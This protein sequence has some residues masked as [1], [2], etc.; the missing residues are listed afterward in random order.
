MSI[1]DV[2]HRVYARRLRRGLTAVPRHIAI[3]TDGNQDAGHIDR[4]LGWCAEVGIPCVSVYA[5]AEVV[6]AVRRQL[7]GPR[8]LPL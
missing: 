2:A 5:A 8:P 4:V 6:E 7:V 1:R 3:V